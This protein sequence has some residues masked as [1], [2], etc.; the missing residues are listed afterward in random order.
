VRHLRSLTV[1][2]LL[3]SPTLGL[4]LVQSI[5]IYTLGI[6]LYQMLEVANDMTAV[7]ICFFVTIA[8]SIGG[9]EIFYRLIEVPSHVLSHV[10]FDW[11]RT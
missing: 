7:A 1:V 3:T 8:A 2:H 5:I 11:I 4:F 10:A 9:A 6:Q